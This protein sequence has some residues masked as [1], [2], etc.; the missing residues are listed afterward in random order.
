MNLRACALQLQI[1]AMIC[2]GNAKRLGPQVIKLSGS[3]QHD[4]PHTEMNM[5]GS[6]VFTAN[7]LDVTLL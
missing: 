5:A 2:N 3:C 1:V 4:S 7:G 6:T